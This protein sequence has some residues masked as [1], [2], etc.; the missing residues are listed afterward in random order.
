MGGGVGDPC[1]LVRLDEMFDGGC[2]RRERTEPEHQIRQRRAVAW[3]EPLEKATRARNL[4]P[5]ADTGG[6]ACGGEERP[7]RVL[8]GWG[9]KDEHVVHGAS[10]WAT[11]SRRGTRAASGRP[12][13]SQSQRAPAP[14]SIS[15]AGSS[16]SRCRSRLPMFP[17][18]VAN[19]S[20]FAMA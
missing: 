16:K 14:P 19:T 1:G 4:E 8:S 9:G 10:P 18:A 13:R 2:P 20:Q 6:L 3:P 11:T 15:S 17:S 12:E 7:G 5:S